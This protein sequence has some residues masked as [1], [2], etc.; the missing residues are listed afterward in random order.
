MKLHWFKQKG[1]FFL[2]ATIVGWMILI[3][4]FAYTI[5][6]FR[7]IDSKSHSASDTLMNFAFHLIIIVAIYTVIAMLF[8]KNPKNKN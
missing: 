1:T 8:S 4:S 5:Y 3:A 7:V 2:P 6:D